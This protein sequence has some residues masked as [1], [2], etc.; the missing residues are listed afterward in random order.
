MTQPTRSAILQMRVTPGVKH[1]A[2]EVIHRL[3]LTMTEAIE[4]FLRRMIVDQRIPFQIVAFDDAT[5]KRLV[6][7]WPKDKHAGKGRRITKALRRSA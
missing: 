2:E 7:D 6:E 5:Y 1:A 3:G 4:L